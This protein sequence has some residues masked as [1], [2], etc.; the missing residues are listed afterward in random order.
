M[1][2]GLGMNPFAFGAYECDVM[3][4]V[5]LIY[6]DHYISELIRVAHQHAID[7]IIPGSD[8]EAL[9]LTDHLEQIESEGFKVLSAG[10][11][12]IR[13][14]RDKAKMCE[15]LAEYADIFVKSFQLHEIRGALASGKTAFP[16]IAKPRDGFASRG[17]E[18]LYAEADLVRVTEQHIIQELAI[19]HEK[20]PFRLQ[21]MNQLARRIN[22]QLSEISIQ[23]VASKS[24]EIL[25]RMASFNK[26]NNGVPIEILPY[27]N[28]SLW[29]EID[30][31]LPALKKL[32]LR[33][34]LNIQGRLTDRGLKIFEMNARFTGITGLRAMMGFNEVETCIKEWL[35][36]RTAADT[37][38]IN[39]DRFG[40]RQTTD[41]SISIARNSKVTA[42]SA[43]INN[44]PVSTRKT[45]LVT[46]ASGYLGRALLRELTGRGYDLIAIGRCRSKLESIYEE[47]KEI[48]CYDYQD[49]KAGVVRLGLI[50]ILI[51]CGFAR[52]HLGPE[53]IADS[54]KMTHWLF[55]LAYASQVAAIINISSQSVYG[56][57]RPLLCNEMATPSPESN[58]SQAKYATELMAE[59]IKSINKH[60][61]VTS[62][63]L[64]TLSGGQ[65]GLAP[66]ELL[67]KLVKKALDHEVLVIKGGSQVLPRLD[68]RDA[69][70]GITALLEHDPA[71]WKPV[72]N[73]GPLVPATLLQL[74]EKVKEIGIKKFNLPVEIQVLP[75][76]SVT[77]LN[78]D[79]SLICRETGWKPGFDLDSTV[80]SLF[81]HEGHDTQA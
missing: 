8:D 5:P 38:R 74:A 40:I 60:M 76:D 46:G 18:I 9:I 43:K 31:L 30:K 71:Q 63:R 15:V 4:D 32:G 3:D 49:I 29:T 64:A 41:K 44:K 69:A 11:D 20:D 58:Y 10:K 70:C 47:N 48:S 72:Y 34:P 17:I 51:H 56:L 22:P 75:D 23:L 36:I 77:S 26:L 14:I 57:R 24:G 54:L 1:T 68:V 50:D 81:D 13:L 73:I 27:E 66:V 79:A 52:P 61:A 78:L 62:I 80:E 6:S 65:D 53:A 28:E 42:L 21:Y 12:L 35:G 16:L 45:I 7:L 59:T 19:P 67:C 39:K 33:G 55:K 37:L 2:I 25:G